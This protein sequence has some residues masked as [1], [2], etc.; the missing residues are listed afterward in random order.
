MQSFHRFGDPEMNKEKSP[1]ALRRRY[2]RLVDR[3]GKT[4]LVLQ[5]SITE[6]TLVREDPKDATVRKRYGPYYQWTRKRG[7]KTVNINLSAARAKAYQKAINHQRKVEK[8]LK[9]MQRL[10]QQILDSTTQ[11]VIKRKPRI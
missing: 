10:S 1:D 6:R 7:G 3:L 2:T 9:E 4:E 8:L 11:G 5:G